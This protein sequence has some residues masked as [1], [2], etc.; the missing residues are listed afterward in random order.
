M[1][2]KA[3]KGEVWAAKD[4]LGW[5]KFTIIGE[6]ESSV[7]YRCSDGALG[8]CSRNAFYELYENTD[9]QLSLFEEMSA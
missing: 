3:K 4:G 7:E 6:T 2:I 9:K 1:S 5:D 8:G